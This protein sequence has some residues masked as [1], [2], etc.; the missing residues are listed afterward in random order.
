M[1][2]FK[3]KIMKPTG[4]VESGIVDLPYEDEFSVISYLESNDNAIVIFVKKLGFLS[5]FFFV[6]LKQCFTKKLKHKFIAEWLN[7]ISIMIKAGM[8]LASALE[9]SVADSERSDFKKDV[10]DMVMGIQRGS[11]FSGVIEHKSR[12]FPKTVL[13]LIRIG[14]ESGSLDERL[15]DAAEHLNRIQAIV[16]DTKQALLYPFFVFFTMGGAMIFWFYY[17]V[18][19]IVALFSDMNVTLPTLTLIVIGIS[20]F[21][22]AY[23]IEMLLSCF[24]FVVIIIILYRK[25]RKFRKFIDIIFLKLPIAGEL[26]K[27]SNLAFITE[28]F[29]L[30][31]NAGIDIIQSVKILEESVSN[32]VFKD[33]LTEIK[34]RIAAGTS[35]AEAFKQAHVFPRFVCRM[36]SIGEVSGTLTEQLQYVAGDYRAKLAVMVAS[37]GKTLE[38][39]VLVIAGIIFAVI[40]AGLFLPIYD[41]VGKVSSM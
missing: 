39:V 22:Q 5:S 9:E 28:Y 40:M 17:V 15:K 26:I 32:E 35:I 30:L 1:N 31:I 12:I 4:D 7:N 14:E 24:L 19:K 3:Y 41:L 16:S 36:I 27:I 29:A 13:Y 25:N 38:P 10:H 23:I 8:P 20:N 11:N 34:N 6:F 18:P 37:L 33:R 2:H 21:I